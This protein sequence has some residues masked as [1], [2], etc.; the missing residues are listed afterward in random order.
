[1]I[2]SVFLLNEPFRSMMKKKQDANDRKRYTERH[3]AVNEKG[4]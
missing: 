2:S 4:N 1:M 3:D